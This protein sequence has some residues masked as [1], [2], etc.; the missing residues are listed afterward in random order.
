[1][2]RDKDVYINSWV[3]GSSRAWIASV[4]VHIEDGMTGAIHFDNTFKGSATRDPHD[5]EDDVAG[6][7]LALGR[8]LEAAGQRLQYVAMKRVDKAEGLEYVI[9]ERD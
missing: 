5:R 4:N 7:E 6:A 3:V 8:A 1:M 2:S 9:V